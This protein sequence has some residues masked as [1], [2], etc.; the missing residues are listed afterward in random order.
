MKQLLPFAFLLLLPALVFAQAERRVMVESF[1][2]ASCPPCAAQNPAFNSLLQ[3]FGDRVVLLK[4]QT[5]WPGFDPMNQQNPGEVAARVSYYGVTGVPNVRLDGVVNGGTAGNV[6]AAMVNNRLNQATPIEMELTHEISP[7]LDSMYIECLIINL[8]TLPFDPGGT[9]LHTAIVEK[10]ILFPTPPGSTNEVDFKSVMRKMLPDASGTTIGAIAPGDTL[11]IA[12]AEPLPSYIYNYAEL[13]AVAFVQKV[14]DRLVYQAAESLPRPIVGNFIDL[15]ILPSSIAPAGLCEYALTP[16]VEISN[17]GGTAID[18]M[19]VSYT[20]NGGEPVI[21]W[22]TGELG[23]GESILVSFPE[24]EIEPGTS[25]LEFFVANANG[26]AFDYNGLN[27]LITTEQFV[28]LSAEP[29]GEDLSES[30]EGAPLRDVP[31]NAVAVKDANDHFMVV[32]R[33]LFNASQQIGG[34]GAS[35]RSLFTNFYDWDDVGGTAHLIFDKIDLSTSENT[36]LRFDYAHAQ[37][38]FSTFNTNDRLRI[39]VSEDCGDTWTTVWDKAGAD[40]ATR[41]PITSRFVPTVAQWASDSI[42]LAAFDGAA[43]LNLR[44]SVTSDW[45]N[46][47]FVDNIQIGEAT[48]VSTD[49]PG[50]LAGKVQVYPN[51]ASSHAR[52]ELALEAPT[53]V[54]ITVFDLNGRRI[55]TLAAG[56]QFAAGLHYLDWSPKSQG[57]FLVRVATEFGILTERVTVLR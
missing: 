50:R 14:S 26:G 24:I 4:Y 17:E 45:G 57:V 25:D 38:P 19:E 43:E 54:D 46:S 31:A 21:E 36:Y 9:V 12:F 18:S 22:W 34:Y 16:Q 41:S 20:L 53:A 44:L 29:I 7:N 47:L 51:P 52:I 28:T 23:A 27:E 32:D 48:I 8:D 39:S 40:L 5:S 15:G 1:T 30:F 2:Q 35:S 3:G 42:S 49:E 6:T 37:Y 13:G 11:R 33:T 56:S 10:R 55:E